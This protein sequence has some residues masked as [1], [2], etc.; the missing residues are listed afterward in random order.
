MT[1]AWYKSKTLWINGIAM[2]AL[3]IQ[4]ITGFVI[5]LETQAAMIVVINLILR[6]ITHE[7][8]LDDSS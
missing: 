5:D 2:L 4:N 7:G 3:L 1:K 6:V 8:L